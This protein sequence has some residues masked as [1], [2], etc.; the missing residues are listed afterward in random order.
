MNEEFE[1]WKKSE[2]TESVLM[3][4][5]DKANMHHCKR[6]VFAGGICPVYGTSGVRCCEVDEFGNDYPNSMIFVRVRREIGKK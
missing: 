2:H 4:I 3:L 1:E 6:C 5:N